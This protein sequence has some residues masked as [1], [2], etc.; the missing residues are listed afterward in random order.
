MF[1]SRDEL[2]GLTNRVQSSAQ[3]R[4]LRA[5]GIE[6]RKRPDGSVAVLRSHVH[7][8]FGAAA[9]TRAPKPV[10]PNWGALNATST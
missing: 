1:L 9:G 3:L 5:M 10:E 2:H 4:V 7:Q 8:I 6:H